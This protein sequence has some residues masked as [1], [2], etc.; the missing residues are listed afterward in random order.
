MKKKTYKEIYD[1]KLNLNV[2]IYADA[3]YQIGG[4]ESWIVY[5]AKKYNQ[6]QITVVYKTIDSGQLERFEKYVKCVQY[7]GQEFHCERLI[8]VAP[9]YIRTDEIYNGAKEK[10][11][12]NHVCYGDSKNTEVFELPKLDGI[13]AVSDFCAESC[14]K[15]M[16]GDIVTLYN[17]VEIDAPD[18]VL[19]LVSACRWSKDKGSVQMLKF[20]EMLDEAK[21]PFIWLIFTDE[22]PDEHHKNMIFMP[23][24]YDLGMFLK[25]ADYGVQFTRIEAQNLFTAECLKLGTPV[26]VTDLPVFREVG[27]N[28]NNAFFY[29]WDMNGKGVRELLNVPKVKYKLPDSSK[30]YKELLKWD[31]LK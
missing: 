3:F 27:I 24:R 18:R 21:I 9:I 28:E 5:V 16:L 31:T 11:L 10:F 25:E 19:K 20:A 4:I 2:V 23:H 15:R 7:T 12:I 17:P 13:F 6:G 1:D 8:Y 26:I 22:E 30:I 29:D 14:K